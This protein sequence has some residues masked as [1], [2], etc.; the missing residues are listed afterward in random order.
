MSQNSSE[1]LLGF[2]QFKLWKFPGTMQFRRHSAF[3]KITVPARKTAVMMHTSHPQKNLLSPFCLSFFISVEL[4][5]RYQ[6]K[7]WKIQ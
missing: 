2:D 3:N 4:I 1:C 6:S 5:I 7:I